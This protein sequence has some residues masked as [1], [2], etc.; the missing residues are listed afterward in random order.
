MF[1]SH[2]V[3]RRELVISQSFFVPSWTLMT[4]SSAKSGMGFG[5]SVRVRGALRSAYTVLSVGVPTRSFVSVVW[6]CLYLTSLYFS[7]A[8]TTSARVGAGVAVSSK[9]AAP[10]S[11][12]RAAV[13]GTTNRIRYLRR[14][15]EATETGWVL[16][17]RAWRTRSRAR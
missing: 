1:A 7:A 8:L 9:S 5:V 6:V 11:R 15:E 2:A 17:V 16:S 10:P 3:L 14:G 13:D 12:T 4:T